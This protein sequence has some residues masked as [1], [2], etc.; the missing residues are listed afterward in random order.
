M[1]AMSIGF[2]RSVFH[3]SFLDGSVGKVAYNVGDPGSVPEWGR[4]PEEGNGNLPQCSLL[5]ESHGQRSLVGCSPWGHREL[6]STERLTLSL[7][8]SI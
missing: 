8:S 3:L 1:R 4:C 7:S 5:R 6:D 2:P